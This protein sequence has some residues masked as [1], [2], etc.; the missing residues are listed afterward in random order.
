VIIVNVDKVIQIFNSVYYSILGHAE[1]LGR[2]NIKEDDVN[3]FEGLSCSIS[4]KEFLEAGSEDNYS[5]S[6]GDG[7]FNWFKIPE[8]FVQ[9]MKEHFESEIQRLTEELIKKGYELVF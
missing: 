1:A 7:N 6:D 4:G 5:V 3:L 2:L 8:Q 9:P